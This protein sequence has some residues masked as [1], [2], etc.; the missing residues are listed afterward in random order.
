MQTSFL[1]REVYLLSEG[2]N[3]LKIVIHILNY[4]DTID[5]LIDGHKTDIKKLSLF[6]KAEFEQ[7][8][9]RGVHEIAVIKK[10]AIM[11]RSWKKGVL[12]DW[13]SCLLGVPDWTLSEKELDKR[14]CSLFIK[15]KVERDIQINLRLTKDGFEIIETADDIL[16]IVKQTETCEAAKKRIKNAYLIPAIIIALIIELCMLI[17]GVFLIANIQYAKSIIVF[18][19]AL[20]WA[21]LVCNMFLKRKRHK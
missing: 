19:L 18:V 8:L 6:S 14:K 7:N 3:N 13:I 17:V 5:V 4:V 21:W 1:W 11:E 20:F 10:S 16:D 2:G 12:Y 15:V 9:E